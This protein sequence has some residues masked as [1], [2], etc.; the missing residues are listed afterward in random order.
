MLEAIVQPDVF[1][2][3]LGITLGVKRRIVR[4]PIERGSELNDPLNLAACYD[5]AELVAMLQRGGVRQATC[6][7]PTCWCPMRR[8]STLCGCRPRLRRGEWCRRQLCQPGRRRRD[9]GR[10]AQRL[11]SARQCRGA[12]RR[13]LE[14]ATFHGLMDVT[15]R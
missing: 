8:C 11:S 2:T 6:R 9:P 7:P 12:F 4:L 3:H 15:H 14:F 5:R 1:D 10:R 13:K